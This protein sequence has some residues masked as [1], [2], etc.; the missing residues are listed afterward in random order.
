VPPDVIDVHVA[1]TAGLDEAALQE[2]RDVLSTEERA[3]ADR[4]V[5]DRDRR[6]FVWA[7]ALLRR[8]LSG[9]APIAPREWTFDIT[10]SGK[11]SVSA[12]QGRLAFNLSHARGIV[13]CAVTTADVDLGVDVERPPE[14]HLM[15]VARRFFARVEADALE[16]C[17]PDERPVR[18]VEIWTLKESFIKA[19][20]DGLRAPLGAFSF[21]LPAGDPARIGFTPPSGESASHWDFQLFAPS[22]AD[23]VALAVRSAEARA[24]RVTA[25]RYDGA[26]LVAIDTP[27]RCTRLGR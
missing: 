10:A 11:P 5:F 25:R 13:A 20:G 16:A 6:D 15:T 27:V 17:A 3:R 19:T 12:A 4:F 18:F 1:Y 26:R 24:W 9:L 8:T 7:H 14:R 22:P 23:R 2:A 21:D